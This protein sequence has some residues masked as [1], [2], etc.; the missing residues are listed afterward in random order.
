MS[1]QPSV[2]AVGVFDGVHLGHQALTAQCA[3]V[4]AEY[5]LMPQALT[6]YPHP[7]SVV[8]GMTVNLLVSLERRV[9]L[10]RAAGMHDVFICEFDAA[11]AAQSPE[12]FI[13]LVLKQVLGATH[14][15]VGK[16][17]RFGRGA[18]GTAETLR[19]AG[20]HVHEVEQVNE[21]GGRV[22]STRIRELI[23]GDNLEL[24]NELLSRAHR[25]EGVVVHGLRRGR[26]LGFPTANVQLDFAQ[27]VPAD[28]VYAGWM[29]V[30]DAEANAVAQWPAAIS[31][32]TNPTFADVPERV[33]EAYALHESDLD[34]Y[35]RR[36]AVDFVQKVR[37]MKAFASVAELVEAMQA[38]VRQ[39]ERILGL[40]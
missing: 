2:V 7:M 13:E 21:H 16:G 15:V 34:V 40:S 32:G 14:V 26:D 20:L 17:F 28:G 11:R 3:A 24:A 1:P 38:D 37:P 6:F 22:S 18:A 4:A 31:V 30:L 8:R 10:L 12:Q 19:D 23:A 35:E 25:L 9:E 29:H 33:V 27:A 5:G 36:L 39:V